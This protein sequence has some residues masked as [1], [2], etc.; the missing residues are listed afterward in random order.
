MTDPAELLAAE[1]V[2]AFEVTGLKPIDGEYL[3]DDAFNATTYDKATCACAIGA[4][5]ASRRRPPPALMGRRGV[6]PV[7]HRHVACVTAGWDETIGGGVGFTL[8]DDGSDCH[9]YRAGVLAATAM[10]TP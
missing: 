6:G 2:A 4:L 10:E 7:P 5:A 3:T 1:I 8:C 9:F